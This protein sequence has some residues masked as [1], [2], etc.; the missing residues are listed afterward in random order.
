MVSKL[1]IIWKQ[2]VPEGKELGFEYDS[3]DDFAVPGF[4]M[5]ASSNAEDEFEA[6]GGRPRSRLQ[7]M[8]AT[9]CR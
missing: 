7:V 6:A 5:D 3:E 2:T 8:R 1:R 4:T 9:V